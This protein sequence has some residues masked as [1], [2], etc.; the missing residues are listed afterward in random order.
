MS[1]A[2]RTC[3]WCSS[4]V[5]AAAVSCPACGSTFA[6]ESLPARPG[7]RSGTSG[8]AIAS[9]VLGIL[10]LTTLP[11]VFPILAIVFAGKAEREIAEGASGDGLASAG[12][13]LGWIGLL[14]DV[15]GVLAILI[16]LSAV[17]S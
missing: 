4:S 5:S 11:F 12:R 13:V 8:S 3:P 10:G 1:T 17:S 6:R 9:L 14:L 15:L 7:I 2:T 16:F